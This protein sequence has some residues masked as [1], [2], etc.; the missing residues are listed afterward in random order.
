MAAPVIKGQEG[1]ST[2]EFALTL[3]LLM[4]L[5]FFFMQLSLVF[6]FGNYVHYATF[7]SARAY[8]S[9]GSTDDDQTNRAQ[10]VIIQ[11]LKRSITQSRIDRFPMIGKGVGGAD[12][13]GF[14]L[15]PSPYA[16]GSNDLSWLQG[17]RYTFSSKL[18][19]I[20]LG[21]P[22]NAAVTGASPNQVTLIS[23][24]WLLREPADQDCQTQ[25]GK[26]HGIYDNGC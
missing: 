16:A 5:V 24:S 9:A 19:W 2:M 20:P 14:Q 22:G 17:V 3:M 25:L 21:G 12:I 6:G 8:L 18:F 26:V 13:P 7:M 10:A 4:A 15:D 1:Q 23:E 11:T